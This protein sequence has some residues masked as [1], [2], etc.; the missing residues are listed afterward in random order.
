M[1]Q[2]ANSR[3]SGEIARE[4]L[5]SILLFEV[6]DPDL[7]LVT[8]TGCEVSVDR[9]FVR[10]YVTCEPERYESVMAALER[11]KGRIRSLLG[12]ALGWR[13]TPELAFSID[14]ST[15]EAE[16]IARALENRPPTID[17]VKDEFGYPVSEA[18]EDAGE[19]DESTEAE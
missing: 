15:D 12:R 11:A 18:S 3:R 9:S 2:N 1:K 5:A 19:D 6:A 16:R 8:L 14:T 10:A 7:D 17:V 13:V 4:K